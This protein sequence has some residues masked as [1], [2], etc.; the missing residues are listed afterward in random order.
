MHKVTGVGGVFRDPK[1]FDKLIRLD[2]V[3]KRGKDN[4]FFFNGVAFKNRFSE[5]AWEYIGKVK[6][7]SQVWFE[8]YLE[9]SEYDNKDGAKVK[10][11]DLILT[12]ISFV[13]SAPGS[14][15]AAPAGEA[16]AKPEGAPKAAPSKSKDE[17]PF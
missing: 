5:K 12:D 9:T 10:S 6:K 16:P 3:S 1:S 8:G 4:A 11:Q 2:I 14:Q 15:G 17:I 7:G 13:G